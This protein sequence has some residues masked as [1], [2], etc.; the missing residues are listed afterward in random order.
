MQ[1][2]VLDDQP[3]YWFAH[4]LLLT[5]SGRRP[6]HTLLGHA[7]PEAYD[8]LAELA[9]GA[10]LRPAGRLSE[11]PYVARCDQYEPRQG[12][13]EAFARVAFGERLAAFAF[14][15]ERGEDER[16]RCA[17]IDLGPEAGPRPGHIPAGRC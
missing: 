6:V 2:Q 9:P 14:R 15:L 12:V 3:R 8:Q 10:P 13:I 5:L 11:A 4:R 7:L 16:W 1:R 17:A